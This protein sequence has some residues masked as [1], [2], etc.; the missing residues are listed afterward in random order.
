MA[1]I[2]NYAYTVTL[3]QFINRMCSLMQETR[4]GILNALEVDTAVAADDSNQFLGIVNEEQR[5]LM[6]AVPALNEAQSTL[7]LAAGDTTAA[8]PATLFRGAAVRMQYVGATEPNQGQLLKYLSPAQFATLGPAV[9]NADASFE[10]PSCYTMDFDQN[11]FVFPEFNTGR[12]I[13]LTYRAA[14][15]NFV[16]DDITNAASTARFVVPD[17]F[18]DCFLHLVTRRMAKA[19]GRR[20]VVAEMDQEL[21]QYRDGSTPGL[22]REMQEKLGY[23]ESTTL[24][25]YFEHQN[26]PGLGQIQQRFAGIGRGRGFR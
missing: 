23:V 10:Y 11:L 24:D 1:N 6:A 26:G 19:M 16:A 7:T 22:F 18:I 4:T 8:I 9:L 21:Y 17:E 5:R 3:Y 2:G 12:S 25:G 13:L 20:E 14:P 15:T